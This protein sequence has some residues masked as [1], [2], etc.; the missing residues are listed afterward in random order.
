MLYKFI[1][2]K[3]VLFDFSL[4]TLG[5]KKVTNMTIKPL[6]FTTHKALEVTLNRLP[7]NLSRKNLLVDKKGM[8]YLASDIFN[9][10]DESLEKT[11]LLFRSKTAESF[12]SA[13][14]V[15]EIYTQGREAQEKLLYSKDLADIL[16]KLRN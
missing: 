8:I 12:Y 1:F 3:I 7:E 14:E 9:A 5:G 16:E 4:I 15:K 2:I 10:P 11:E 6:Y 13:K